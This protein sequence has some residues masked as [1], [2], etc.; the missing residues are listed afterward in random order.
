MKTLKLT[1]FTLLALK[2]VSEEVGGVTDDLSTLE[3]EEEKQILPT[4]QLLEPHAR[5]SGFSA[6]SRAD[7]HTSDGT[8][9]FMAD[10]PSSNMIMLNVDYASPQGLCKIALI[11]PNNTARKPLILK[12]LQT[13]TNE[14][15]LFECGREVGLDA[16][17]VE[18]PEKTHCTHCVLAVIWQT[19]AGALWECADVMLNA[20]DAA[21]CDVKCL[22]GGVCQNGSCVCAV[23]YMGEDCSEDDPDSS[24]ILATIGMLL[25]VIFLLLL[26]VAVGFKCWQKRKFILGHRMESHKP[27]AESKFEGVEDIKMEA[28]TKSRPDIN[29]SRSQEIK[30][31]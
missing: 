28:S 18:F 19:E 22:N 8:S 21:T 6:D 7:C 25:L 24:H 31:F 29:N 10:V 4:A 23:G 2:I 11:T 17:V 26:V 9:Y 12:P 20:D 27:F 14:D 15:G 1:L 30:N 5:H 13:Q 3:E 16:F